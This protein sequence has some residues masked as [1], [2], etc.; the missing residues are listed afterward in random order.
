MDQ[1]VERAGEETEPSPAVP[2]KFIALLKSRKFWAA[3]V[4]VAL[5]I[6]KEYDPQFPLTEDQLTN[7]VYVVVA[8]IVGTSL[9][10]GLSARKAVSNGGNS[11]DPA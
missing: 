3:L 7:L 2:N 4:G 1:P 8:Y 11:L 5:I 9:E 10:D 6:V